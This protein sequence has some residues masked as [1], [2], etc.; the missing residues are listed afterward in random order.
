MVYK[1][2][3]TSL[4][5]AVFPAMGIPPDSPCPG[6]DQ[7]TPPWSLPSTW[8]LP[9]WWPSPWRGVSGK[10]DVY[11][12]YT[13][14]NVYVIKVCLNL[15]DISM[16]RALYVYIIYIYINSYEVIIYKIDN[17][18]FICSDWSPEIWLA[19]GSTFLVPDL[20]MAGHIVMFDRLAMENDHL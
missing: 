16:Y 5:G 19:G 7:G 6:F 15:Y 17:L 14:I 8:P 12:W 4:G 10:M 18:Y 9:W 1:P 11:I 2:R 13:Y 3:F 20:Q